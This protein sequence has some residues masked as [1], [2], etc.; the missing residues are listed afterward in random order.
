MSI[1]TRQS[2]MKYASTPRESIRNSS[3]LMLFDLALG[4]HHG[5]YIQHLID[6]AHQ[7]GFRGALDIV[8]LPQFAEVHQ[9]VV[10][11][12]RRAKQSQIEIELVTISAEEATGL[13]SR[14]SGM[15]RFRRNFREWQLFC[16]YAEAL[17]TTHALIM[18]LDTCEL[19]LAMG[20]R[21]PC[22][23]S[24]IYFRP[25]FHYQMF[26]NYKPNFKDKQQ[27][28]RERLTWVRI[29]NH[30]QLETVF[31]LDPFAVT[32]L[33][34][35]SQNAKVVH[36]PDPVQPYPSISLDLEMLRT[37]LRVETDRRVFLLFGGLDE[38]KGIYQLLEAIQLLS[39]ELCE[40]LCLLLVGGT[41]PNQQVTIRQKIA[42]ICQTQPLQVI[43][44]YEFIPE[45]DV[46]SYF[47]LAD[48]I[49]APYQRHVGMSG[50]LLLAAAAGKPVLSSD[51]GLMGELAQQYQLG[52]VVDSTK[53]TEIAK[54]LATLL[55]APLLSVANSSQMKLFAEQNSIEQYTNTIFQHLSIEQLI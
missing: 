41:D 10:A 3:R 12:I 50:I 21:S 38:R 22:P 11:A 42:V 32:A 44:H 43:E 55:W 9:D 46:P 40:H 6:W 5:N 49:L 34:T 28:W 15:S 20:M 53:P 18:Y 47:Q 2:V 17:Q 7:Q 30:P 45:A 36:L 1:K 8:V 35:Q 29:L 37:Q 48:A 4:G 16:N 39:P 33:S 24:G 52:L 31:C 23:F 19:P 51:Y 26:V 27:Q 54:A 25:T 14:D 13:G